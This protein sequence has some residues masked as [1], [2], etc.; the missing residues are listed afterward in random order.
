MIHTA[1]TDFQ[2]N[3]VFATL[4]I[5]LCTNTNS[6]VKRFAQTANMVARGNRE[7]NALKILLG[8]NEI[9]ID[10][11]YYHADIQSCILT[12]LSIKENVD[13]VITQICYLDVRNGTS[14]VSLRRHTLVNHARCHPIFLRMTL[15]QK[16]H[17]FD[18]PTSSKLN[19]LV[20][21]FPRFSMRMNFLPFIWISITSF[22]TRR[23]PI[24]SCVSESYP[25]VGLSPFHTRVPSS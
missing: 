11:I 5:S 24:R 13:V 17:R 6:I 7:C 20:S 3:S 9:S 18:K 25:S 22:P 23:L 8:G 15:Q 2:V 1:T 10:Y 16:T 19:R 12:C 4:T 21:M 14:R